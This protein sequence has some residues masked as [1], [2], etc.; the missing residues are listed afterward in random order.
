MKFE[1]INEFVHDYCHE[2]EMISVGLDS[3]A[4]KNIRFLESAI[5]YLILN[6]EIGSLYT[7]KLSETLYSL[8]FA[9]EGVYKEEIN[10]FKFEIITD[11]I[12]KIFSKKVLSQ[13]D[14]YC[15]LKIIIGLNISS[16]NIKKGISCYLR[17]ISKDHILYRL[18][19]EAL[20]LEDKLNN[21][22]RD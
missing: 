19:N 10:N 1:I 9:I 2:Q 14:A 5:D 3:S 11:V 7:L 21:T 22:I 15:I 6:I 16:E 17:E 4:I 8:R 12:E 18:C 20:L 13:I